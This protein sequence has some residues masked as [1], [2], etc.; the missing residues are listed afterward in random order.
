MH[1]QL[2][3]S[4][5]EQHVSPCRDV[6]YVWQR[7][8][9]VYVCVHAHAWGARMGRMARMNTRWWIFMGSNCVHVRDCVRVRV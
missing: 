3:P 6:A 9:C 4:P 5:A 8:A 1:Q 7:F 2:G